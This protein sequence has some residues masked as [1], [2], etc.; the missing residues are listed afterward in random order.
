VPFRDPHGRLEL[1]PDL[2]SRACVV[3]K[4]HGAAEPYAR[5]LFAA[6]FA[7]EL[8]EV[9]RAR[10]VGLAVRAGMDQA[11]FAEA[12]DAD[13]TRAEQE[14]VLRRAIARGAFGVPSFVVG[15]RLFWGNDRLVLLRRHLL[16]T[17][18]PP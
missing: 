2:L 17:H 1:D 7:E 16:G 12:L 8:P 5:S 18:S 13:R 10:C 3:A 15:D 4:R 14:E 6:I 11:A 9:D